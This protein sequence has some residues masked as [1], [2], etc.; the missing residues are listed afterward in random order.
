MRNKLPALLLLLLF[1]P[2]LLQAQDDATRSQVVRLPD[3]GFVAFKSESAR[4]D[5]SSSTEFVPRLQ[6]GLRSQALIGD[7]QTIHRVLQNPKGEY[8][9]GYDLI[10]LAHADSKKFTKIGRASRRERV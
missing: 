1:A 2:A 4:T 5:N 6:G 9:F 3:G 7:D 10:V 8:I